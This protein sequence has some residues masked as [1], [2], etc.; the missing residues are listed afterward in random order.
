MQVE[1]EWI[2]KSKIINEVRPTIIYLPFK[3]DVHRKIFEAVQN[4]LDI[5]LLRKYIWWKH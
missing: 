4:R 1:Y 2:D 5:P 3:G